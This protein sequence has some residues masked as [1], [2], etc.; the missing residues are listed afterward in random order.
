MQM[1]IDL[2]GIDRSVYKAEAEAL[3]DEA[4]YPRGADGGSNWS[5]RWIC[6]PFWIYGT[7]CLI[8]PLD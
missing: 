3:L 1:A 7:D 8:P 2:E 6:T 4:G 5:T